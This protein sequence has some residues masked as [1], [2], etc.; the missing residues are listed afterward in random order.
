[1]AFTVVYDANVL[2]PAGLRDLL[3]RLAQTGL[4]RARWTEHILDEVVRSILAR[5]PDLR[6]AQLDR[7]R[8]L[9]CEAVADC[10]VTGH[11][12]LIEGL[13]LPD[14]D[15]RHVLA[16]AIRCHAQV[17]VTQ[18]LKDFPPAALE[19]FGIEAQHPD[20]FVLHVVDLAPARVV[21]VIERQANALTAP[22]RTAGDLLNALSTEIPRAVTALR[23]HFGAGRQTLE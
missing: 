19:P 8:Q 15:D 18:N 4:F 17:I 21:A 7:T 13:A 14:P 12:P 22:P 20:L 11:E 10:L 23:S 16:A 1:M 2:H 6:P 5:R 9:M 3:I